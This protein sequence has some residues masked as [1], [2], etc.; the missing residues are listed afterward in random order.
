[1]RM[2]LAIRGMRALVA[3]LVMPAAAQGGINVT[4]KSVF[5]VQCGGGSGQPT[6]APSSGG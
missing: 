5:N 1:M 2:V 4:G 3:A 6:V